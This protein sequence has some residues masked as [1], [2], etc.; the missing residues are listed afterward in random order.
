MARLV[1][2]AGGFEISDDP[3]RLD[4]ATIHRFISEESYWARGRD[5]ATV[6]RALAHSLCFGIYGPDGAQVGFARLVTD[7]TTAAHLSDVYVLAAYRGRGLSKALLAAILGH[8]ELRTIA[9]WTLS[10]DDAH[11]LYAGFGFAAH[12][13]VSSQMWRLKRPDEAWKCDVAN[14]SS[15]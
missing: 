6:E 8:P 5:R 13:E 1:A 2:L 11:G 3:A 4:V 14:S 12:P 9:R 7:R 10:T 15:G